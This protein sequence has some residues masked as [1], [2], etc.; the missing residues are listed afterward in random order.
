MYSTALSLY[1]NQISDDF[2]TCKIEKKNVTAVLKFVSITINISYTVYT[3]LYIM[4]TIC[5]YHK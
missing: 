5:M 3:C 4:C 2:F 1:Y